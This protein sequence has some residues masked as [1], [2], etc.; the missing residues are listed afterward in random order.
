[1]PRAFYTNKNIDYRIEKIAS[2]TCDAVFIQNGGQNKENIYITRKTF[3]KL[4]LQVRTENTDRLH[5]Y[6]LIIDE[7]FIEYMKYQL[8][9]KEQSVENIQYELTSVKQELKQEKIHKN[10]IL[11][12]KFQNVQPCHTIY[13]YKNDVDDTS[14]TLFK[15]GK[16]KNISSREQLYNNLSKKGEMLYVQQCLNCDLT[17]RVL[18]HL[19][20]KYRVNSMQEWFDL[21]SRTFAIDMM[22][23]VIDLLDTHIDTI[24]TTFLSLFDGVRSET[25]SSPLPQAKDDTPSPPLI[26]IYE[27]EKEIACPLPPPLS[28]PPPRVNPYDFDLF[29]QECCDVSSSDL[30]NKKSEFKQAHRVWSKCATRN[31][32]LQLEKYL[33]QRFKSGIEYDNHIKRNVYR[34]IRLKELTYTP[35]HDPPL[36]YEAFVIETCRFGWHHRISYVDFFKKFVEWKNQNDVTSSFCLTLSYKK[37]IQHAL[38]NEFAAGRVHYSEDM[39]STHLFG[40]WGIG[41][42]FNNYGLKQEIRNCKKLYQCAL[43]GTVIQIF[44]SASVASHV[45]NRPLSSISTAAR[46][47]TSYKNEYILK[48]ET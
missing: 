36:D 43:D 25:P 24:D 23:R 47:N 10:K 46:F 34:G 39:S 31:V 3:K 6:F 5:E 45:L 42:D 26:P 19:L 1:L 16:S 9:Y 37:V 28:P 4:C 17:E 30:Y 48:Y 7:I 11:N 32:V 40:V 13:L 20:D 12:R 44:D 8:R 14:S 29:V 38:E 15:I 41:M 33:K 22:K 21:P 2:Q 27:H 35:K 18:H